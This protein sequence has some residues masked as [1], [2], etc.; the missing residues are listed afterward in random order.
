MFLF[1]LE[2]LGFIYGRNVVSMSQYVQRILNRIE[3]TFHYH[4]NSSVHIVMLKAKILDMSCFEVKVSHNLFR[5]VHNLLSI[6]WQDL[7]H[8]NWMS[9]WL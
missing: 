5:Q 1:F 3:S 2:D 9:P 4:L 8:H 7:A 6:F